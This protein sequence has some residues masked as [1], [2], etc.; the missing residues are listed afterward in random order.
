[1]GY[2]FSLKKGGNSD[3]CYNTMNL[4]D[5]MLK[6]IRQTQKK[7]NTVQFHLDD[8]PKVVTLIESRMVVARIWEEGEW[9]ICCLMATDF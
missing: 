6:E 3:T 2:L 4:E 9:G 7:T 5:V 8:V 1:M